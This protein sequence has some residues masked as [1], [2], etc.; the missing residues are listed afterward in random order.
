[1][2]TQFNLAH[3]LRN[4]PSLISQLVHMSLYALAIETLEAVRA[5]VKLTDE[6]LE[7]LDA[8]LSAFDLHVSLTVAWIGERALSDT[9]MKMLAEN[10]WEPMRW[11]GFPQY[12]RLAMLQ[13]YDSLLLAANDLTWSDL[14]IDPGFDLE[15]PRYLYA[16]ASLLAPAHDAA[17]TTALQMEA[18]IRCNRVALAATRYQQQHG[19]WPD[20]VETLVPDYLPEVLNDPFVSDQP[21]IMARRPFGLMVYSIGADET[22][23]GGQRYNDKGIMYKPGSDILAL[24]FATPGIPQP[25]VPVPPGEADD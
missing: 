20:S 13:Y 4:E 8:K 6:Q 19:E 25:G 5:R 22:D 15:S 23:D 10:Q 11:A 14:P 17:M 16:Y 3:A 18:T 2:L 24:A 21:L 12:N 1:M 7:Q 9:M